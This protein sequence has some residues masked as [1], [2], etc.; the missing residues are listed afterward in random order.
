MKAGT[1]GSSLPERYAKKGKIG[2]G[3]YGVVYK[4]IDTKSGDVVAIKKIK[5]EVLI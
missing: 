4:G 3:A 1:F 2:G 5:L